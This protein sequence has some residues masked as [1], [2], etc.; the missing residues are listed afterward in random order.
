MCRGP[1]AGTARLSPK[2]NLAPFPKN[3]SREQ[4][5]LDK[6]NFDPSYYSTTGFLSL[7]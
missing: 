2:P 4:E 1:F 7:M 6:G 3:H 5:K